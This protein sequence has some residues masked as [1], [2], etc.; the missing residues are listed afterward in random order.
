MKTRIHAL[1]ELSKIALMSKKH[2]KKVAEVVNNFN[3]DLET[4]EKVPAKKTKK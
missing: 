2:V 1:T 4:I 3:K